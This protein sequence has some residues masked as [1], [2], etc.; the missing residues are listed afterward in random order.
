MFLDVDFIK[1]TYNLVSIF[2]RTQIER[3]EFKG[4]F[5]SF[6]WYVFTLFNDNLICL[7]T[8]FNTFV[9]LQQVECYC[10]KVK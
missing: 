1:K 5:A 4:V 2:K 10:F 3:G 7:R 8:R 9:S 6:L